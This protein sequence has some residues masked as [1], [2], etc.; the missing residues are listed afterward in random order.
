MAE[1]DDLDFGDDDLD[2]DDDSGGDSGDDFAGELDDMMGDDEL[3][4]DSGGDSDSDSEL[5]SFF[6]D[7]SSIED[8]DEGGDS[9]GDEEPEFDDTAAAEEKPAPV[10]VEKTKPAKKE[11]GKLKY[12]I[13]VV[14][15]L[16]AVG[17]TLAYNFFLREPEM[18]VPQD[19]TEEV[20][21]PQMLPAQPVEMIPAPPKKVPVKPIVI[22]PVEPAP[23]PKPV[24]PKRLYLV[25][26]AT[27][28]YDTCKN[29]FVTALRENG[30][31]VYQKAIGD[32]Y[33]MIELI[34]RE[35][36]TKDEANAL[37]RELN[38]YNKMAGNAYAVDQ[39]NG[40]RVSMGT[41]PALDRA[42]EIKFH[43]EHL[44]PK[45]NVIFNLEHV[46]KPYASTK[47]YAGPYESR[48][49]AKKVLER[50]RS[51]D[52]FKGAFLIQTTE[53]I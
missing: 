6:E 3:G 11:G 39:S 20:E 46:T 52:M 33:D 32:K 37:A 24:T 36:F 27:C 48:T 38:R 47:V 41:F 14:I 18:M 23:A 35:V 53:R 5:D 40:Y 16:V 17:G 45:D 1:E 2:L 12:V 7:L 22:E 49:V 44:F 8:M 26:V 4:G 28:T 30:E 29:D 19:L 34:S 21:V 10:K 51:K 31:P 43:V 15:L 13:F 9:E 25:Q 50:L 42:K